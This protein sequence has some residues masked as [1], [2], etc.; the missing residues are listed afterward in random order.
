MQAVRVDPKVWFSAER[1]F[2]HWAKIA[3]V[4][5]ASATLLI[6][7]AGSAPRG[8][9]YGVATSGT[10]GRPVVTGTACSGAA[11]EVGLTVQA[12]R[13]DGHVRGVT[14]APP[15]CYMED[16]VLKFNAKGV[17]KGMCSAKKVCI[18]EEVVV[19]LFLYIP[20]AVLG[21]ASLVV[22]GHAYRKHLK[23]LGGLG[24][25]SRMVQASDFADKSGAYMIAVTM[26]LAI[27]G[28]VSAPFISG[29]EG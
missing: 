22:L 16:G 28:L 26:S 5:A 27:L 2:L 24:S 1:T 11:A 12:A 20:A 19:D 17:N 9:T 21:I 7:S 14:D 25:E 10:C 18:C 6:T 15:Y 23:R 8:A 13:N 29:Q 3:V 4:F